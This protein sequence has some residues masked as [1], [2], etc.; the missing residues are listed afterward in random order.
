MR[1]TNVGGEVRTIAASPYSTIVYGRAFGNKH[2]LHEDINAFTSAERGAIVV[3]PVE[4]MLRLLYTFEHSVPGVN[5][6]PDFDAWVQELPMGALDQFSMTEDGG[7][8]TAVFQEIV[9]CFFP[10]LS[11]ENVGEP[12]AG[13][14]AEPT[15]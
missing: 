4:A 9:N 15:T 11:S 1:K 14:G 12:E 10:R 7:W 5:L 13:D 6:V 2:S 8:A 3:L